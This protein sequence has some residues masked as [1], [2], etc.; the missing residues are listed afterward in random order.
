ML[1]Y[2]G[3]LQSEFHQVLLVLVGANNSKEQGL[4]VIVRVCAKRTKRGL[5]PEQIGKLPA[6]D[7]TRCDGMQK[8]LVLTAAATRF[9]V[10]YL[11]LQHHYDS[12]P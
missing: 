3:L 11:G 7:V 6:R 8:P 10:N 9:K 1:A 4:T 5:W 12:G 2:Y